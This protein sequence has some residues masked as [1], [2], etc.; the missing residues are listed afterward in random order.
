MFSKPMLS[1]SPPEAKDLPIDRIVEIA[2]QK[3][4]G[5]N[6]TVWFPRVP[7]AVY[8]VTANNERGPGQRDVVHR[9]R[10]G[11]DPGG[12]LQ[13]SAED[14]CTGWGRGTIRCTSA[15]SGEC[16]PRSCGW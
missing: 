7:N 8:L 9:P 13:Q 11:R 2:Q 15:R 16:R 1:K 10:L 4:P 12:P 6:L 3:M 14:R 5:N